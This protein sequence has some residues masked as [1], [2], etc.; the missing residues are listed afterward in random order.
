MIVKFI[1]NTKGCAHCCWLASLLI[2]SELILSSCLLAACHSEPAPALSDTAIQE[3]VRKVCNNEKTRIQSISEMLSVI[4]M[5]RIDESLC[6]NRYKASLNELE[7]ILLIRSGEIL[8]SEQAFET[9]KDYHFKFIQPIRHV[10]RL[11]TQFEPMPRE[12]IKGQLHTEPPD[13]RA[14]FDRYDQIYMTPI[15]VRYF[16]LSYSLQVSYVCKM[17]LIFNLDT[18]SLLTEDELTILAMFDQATPIGKALSTGLEDLNF[19]N[20]IHIEELDGPVQ[21]PIDDQSQ[22]GRKAHLK[23]TA[24]QNS[25]LFQLIITCKNKFKPIYDKLILPISKLSKLGYDYQG[26]K[27]SGVEQKRLTGFG[28]KT[29]L[30]VMHVCELFENAVVV[31]DNNINSGKSAINSIENGNNS[32]ETQMAKVEDEGELVPIGETEANKLEQGQRLKFDPI[33]Y[34]MNRTATLND[35]LMITGTYNLELELSRKEGHKNPFGIRGFFRRAASQIKRALAK[36]DLERFAVYR[37]NS[38]WFSGIL[39]FISSCS[40]VAS[41]S[42]TLASVWPIPHL[43]MG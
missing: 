1:E 31:V 43:L 11:P 37:R 22:Y 12:T 16:F 15:A 34:R 4:Q 13:Y 10:N 40:N 7:P 9:I 29:W 18:R 42:I 27:F 35:T 20:A 8:C 24:N 38:L 5:V 23:T 14:H 41:I 32:T 25:S 30:G 6:K 17:N 26:D 36:L 39:N 3:T 2:I 33:E 19:D 28:M 21:K